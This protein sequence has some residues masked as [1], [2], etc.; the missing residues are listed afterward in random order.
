MALD[1]PGWASVL[2]DWAPY[3]LAIAGFAWRERYSS[4]K[5]RIRLSTFMADTEKNTK[6][7]ESHSASIANHTTLLEIYR[8]E[9]SGDRLLLNEMNDKLNT[10]LGKLQGERDAEDRARRNG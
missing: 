10:L 4:T 6:L 3:I 9:R 1:T 8:G 2:K 7:L 5:E